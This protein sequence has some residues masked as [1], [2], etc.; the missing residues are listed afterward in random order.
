[1]YGRTDRRTSLLIECCNEVL[2]PFM[3][4]CSTYLGDLRYF[5]KGVRMDGRTYGQTLLTRCED[6]SKSAKFDDS[7][8]KHGTTDPGT[9]D[10]GIEMLVASKKGTLLK[11]NAIMECLY[12]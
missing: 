1:M 8:K 5:R 6:A 4:I 7:E 2:L 12:A 3:L 9:T 11:S 10:P